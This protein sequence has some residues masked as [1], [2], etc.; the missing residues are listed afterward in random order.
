[1]KNILKTVLFSG[2]LFLCIYTNAQEFE[3]PVLTGEEFSD[4]KVSIGADFALQYQAI[5]HWAD[6]AL[7][8]LGKG[9]NL[10]T[11]NLNI[12]ADLAKG[13]RLNLVTYLSSRHHNE[14]WVKG[15]YLLIDE[16]PF[17]NSSAVD[18]IMDYLT[19]KVGVMELNYGDAHFQRS[20]NGN[21]I[22]NPFVGN[23]VM[24][25]FTTAPAIEVLF[26]S[27]GI[28]AMGAVTS[29]TL[30]PVLSTYN[31][32]A[33]Y[34]SYNMI[35]DLL[36]FYWKA[37][38]DKQLTDDFRFRATV[39]GYHNKFHHS[40]SLYN[41]DRAGSRYY[42]VMNLRTNSPDNVDITKN[43]LSGNWSP[44]STNKNNAFMLNLFTKYKG[45]E[46]FGTYE[47]ASGTKA[48]GGEE[49]DF[50][51]LAVEGL[52]RFGKDEQFFAGSRYNKVLN[53]AD[54]AVDRIQGIL[55]WKITPNIISKLEYVHQTYTGFAQYGS[56]AGFKGLVFEAGISF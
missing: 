26:R 31:A 13:I 23:Y 8:P 41:G 29:G 39:S 21:I 45:F 50:N 52:Y 32:S 16:L 24:D 11:A 27:N 51:Q 28:I 25:A 18:N 15:G 40:G 34:K 20:D 5:S 35:N 56:D 14:T 48:V 19:V 12:N 46:L 4:V 6:S 37:G 17:I 42:L 7:I 44:G 9:I 30:K 22:R 1:M 49:F 54:L 38:Y 36:A 33:G 43:H 3:E 47:T 55:G 53:Q 10:P 2:M